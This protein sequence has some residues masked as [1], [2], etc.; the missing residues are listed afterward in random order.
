MKKLCMICLASISCLAF[1]AAPDYRK[2]FDKKNY[3]KM[4][5]VHANPWWFPAKQRFD[6]TG[7]AD[8]AFQ[9]YQTQ[10]QWADAFEEMSKNGVKLIQ[11]ELDVPAPGYANTLKNMIRQC[12]EKKVDCKFVLFMVWYGRR[13]LDE[14]IKRTIHQLDLLKDEL[15]N[16]PYI[17]RLNG[18]PVISVYT[19]EFF[20]PEEWGKVMKAVEDRFGH[21][22]WLMNTCKNPGDDAN[23]EKVNKFVRAYLPYFDGVTQYANYTE[24]SQKK[25][26]E[27]L[28]PIMHNEYPQKI[29]ELA[30]QNTYS[31]HHWFGGFFTRLS[32][33]W[34]Q[35]ID[36]VLK[37][38]PDA[39]TITNMFDHYEQS[40][41]LPS[42]ER[43]NFLL[44][45]ATVALEKW[46]QKSFVG[47]Y[48][49]ELALNSYISVQL[50]WNCLDFEVVGFPIHP[51]C[52]GAQLVTLKLDLCNTAGKV[53]YTF[54]DKVIDV[55][56]LCVAEF[57]VPSEQ[58]AQERGIVPRLRYRWN[59]RDFS[60]RYGPMT[61]I[62]PSIRTNV[63]FWS[64]SNRN[65]LICN[66]IDSKWRMN[67]AG[68]G[69]TL[70]WPSDGIVAIKAAVSPLWHKD[71]L[72]RTGDCSFRIMRNGVEVYSLY[73]HLGFHFTRVH[74][75]FTPG[76][77]LNWYHL[78]LENASGYK[79]A[80]L[81]IWMCTNQRSGKVNVP[82][83]S[84]GK[85]VEMQMEAVRVPYFYYPCRNDTGSILSDHSGYMHNGSF[86]GKHMDT[87]GYNHYY[88]G[89]GQ[90]VKKS[91]FRRDSDGRGY[92]SLGGEYAAMLMGG[93]A[94]P[95]A[96]TYELSVRPAELG[97]KMGLIGSGNNQM[98][99]QVNP[100]GTITVQRGSEKESVGGAAQ[101]SNFNVILQSKTKLQTGKWTR[102]AVVFDLK[103]LQLYMDGKLEAEAPA[104]H[105]MG[106]VAINNMTVGSLCLNYFRKEFFFNGDIREI[107]FYGRNLSTDEFLK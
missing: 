24:E 84:Q 25:H 55:S 97:K 89:C 103:K 74:D 93:T 91:F 87:I 19:P 54:P 96:S 61:L 69:E 21:F 62:N 92:L 14:E 28:A 57:S 63:M 64:R 68:D 65:Q 81:P 15:K 29:F 9:K 42:Y 30:L 83:L 31:C 13:D 71:A 82:V 1:S 75:I 45:Y 36:H 73:K 16:E 4:I 67:E 23:A 35:C 3:Q 10:T 58:F 56:R 11:M 98:S 34:R 107:R 94:F 86:F 40:H 59:N 27:L 88:N 6:D 95:G 100:D 39:I 43:E 53:L 22:I 18:S 8:Y 26:Y 20:K 66:V 105:S 51:D 32:R 44:R 99:I 2:A 47:E 5:S 33:K 102:L 46:N 17:Y 80:T 104:R 41:V 72:G 101:T 7:S 38:N 78:E 37:A 12:K 106:H 60:M 85:V 48:S 79:Y 52:K 77:A 70:V 50:G 76:G 90:P 49:P